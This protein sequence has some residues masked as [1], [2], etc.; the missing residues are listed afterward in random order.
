MEE[1][2]EERSGLAKHGGGGG[3]A[4]WWGQAQQCYV[5]T[6]CIVIGLTV[7]V[8]PNVA[9]GVIEEYQWLV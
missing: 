1:Q 2:D 5:R 8:G 7:L 9:D 6:E 4:L 3:W